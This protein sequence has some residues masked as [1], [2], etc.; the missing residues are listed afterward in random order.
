MNSYLI[1]TNRDLNNE[2]QESH[3]IEKADSLENMVRKEIK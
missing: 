2:N 3:F 1:E